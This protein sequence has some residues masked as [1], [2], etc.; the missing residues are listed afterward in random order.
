MCIRIIYGFKAACINFLRIMCFLVAAIACEYAISSV[1]IL[2]EFFPAKC[3]LFVSK[4]VRSYFGKMIFFFRPLRE[5]S[6]KILRM[7]EDGLRV[8]N[9]YVEDA[10]LIAAARIA[11]EAR[12]NALVKAQLEKMMH[13][14]YN[15]EVA[16][17]LENTESTQSSPPAKK[18]KKN[19]NQI[20]I[21]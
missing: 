8:C 10:R 11:D 6:Q 20:G 1:N 9:Q 17:Q 18:T 13:P 5:F 3:F 19:P 16:A 4:K 2:F 15:V 12:E 21:V 7:Q 14:V